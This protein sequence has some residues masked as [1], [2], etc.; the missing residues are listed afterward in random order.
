M[1]LQHYINDTRDLMHD[2]RGLFWDDAQL[3]RYINLARSQ[4]AVQSGCINILI[5]G[6]APFGG[7]AVAGQ[8]IPGG[9]TPGMPATNTFQTIPGVEKYSYAFGNDYVKDLNQNLAGIGDVVSVS[10]SWGG[11]RP[12]LDWLPW[13][14]LQ[15]YAR[16]YNIGV[17]SYPFMFST[18]GDGN[19][20][21][22]W[23][24]PIPTSQL[25]ME[26]QVFAIPGNL[27]SDSDYEAIPGP[28]TNYVPFYAAH[29]AYLNSQRFGQANT[30][31]DLFYSNSG[32]SRVSADRGKTKS[33]YW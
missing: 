17:T 26:W 24:F 5:P 9:A 19:N 27:Y 22:V 7:Q 25:E 2:K 1:A 32:L 16:S 29:L 11:M 33:F 14:D 8:F 20:G 28:W 10:V 12:S 6:V 21:Q 15:A 18:N 23:L 31:L 13:E 30:M 4:V 3:T